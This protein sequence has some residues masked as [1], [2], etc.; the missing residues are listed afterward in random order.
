M[1]DRG[2]Q[3]DLSA[4]LARAIP[5]PGFTQCCAAAILPLAYFSVSV[6]SPPSPALVAPC[7]A[8]S[9]GG[10]SP[11]SPPNGAAA[12]LSMM[13]VVDP[14]A[15][16][17]QAAWPKAAL[18]GCVNPGIAENVPEIGIDS[19]DAA[20]ETGLSAQLWNRWSRESGETGL[21]EGMHAAMA[22]S[23]LARERSRKSQKGGRRL[24]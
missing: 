1:V 18:A 6:R 5:I 20:F 15:E 8:L 11:C 14:G 24:P 23:R 7:S 2:V 19:Q 12:E 13:R 10:S 4:T 22:P 21:R 16:P 17:L 9:I 3:A